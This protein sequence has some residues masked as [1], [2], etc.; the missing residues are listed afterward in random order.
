M[1]HFTPEMDEARTLDALLGIRRGVDQAELLHHVCV[2][3]LVSFRGF[4]GHLLVQGGPQ[5]RE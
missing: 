1:Q 5:Y 2:H 4:K 3:R